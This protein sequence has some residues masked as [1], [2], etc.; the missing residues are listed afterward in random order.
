MYDTKAKETVLN[1]KIYIFVSYIATLINRQ[2]FADDETMRPWTEAWKMCPIS[3]PAHWS[4]TLRRK[5]NTFLCGFVVIL[6]VFVD[7]ICL[8]V[9]ILRV[10]VDVICLFVVILLLILSIYCLFVVI[11]RVF[12]DVICLFVV[13]LCWIPEEI[14][15]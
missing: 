5:D 6:R 7:V 10:F 11:L 12:V 15:V 9:V 1:I 3:A 4:K 8:F 14:N 2:L 13:I